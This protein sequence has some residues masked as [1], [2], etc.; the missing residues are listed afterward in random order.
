MPEDPEYI[1]PSQVEYEGLN[2]IV[3]IEYECSLNE[4]SNS[5]TI[6]CAVCHASR[7]DAV[8][9]IPVKAS[10]PASWTREYY[11]YLMSEGTNW[12]DRS[13][14]M[15]EC[16]DKDLEPIVDAELDQNPG[17]VY[18]VET[19]CDLGLPLFP[20]NG[21]MGLNCVVCTK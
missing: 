4:L 10:C 6:P 13:P 19:D 3:G 7:R 9:M 17:V 12:P 15:Y 5:H 11:G 16:I 2:K 8:L 1:L 21:S 18:H 14:T 20:Y